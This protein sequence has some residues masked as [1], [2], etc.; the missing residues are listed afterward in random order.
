[1]NLITWLGKF[2]TSLKK[3]GGKYGKSNFYAF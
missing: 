2:Y 1:M 3:V